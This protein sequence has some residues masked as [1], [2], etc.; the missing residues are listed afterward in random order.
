MASIGENIRSTRRKRG[1]SQEQLADSL[2]VTKATICRYENGA[3]EP[4]YDQLFAIAEALNVTV[5]FL[6]GCEPTVLPP[7]NHRISMVVAVSRCSEAEF[8]KLLN[9]SPE[10]V[11]DLC[12]GSASPSDSTISDICGVFGVDEY[13]L[14]TG[15]G[16]MLD[17]PS[18]ENKIK[19]F[20]KALNGN[21]ELDVPSQ[22]LA[23]LLAGC[24]DNV[25]LEKL[26]DLAKQLCAAFLDHAEKNPE[27]A[28]TVSPDL[29]SMC[30]FYNETSFQI[31]ESIIKKPPQD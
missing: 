24:T 13:W 19:Q 31:F 6:Q 16:K 10:T 23:H 1:L 9:L 30:K 3:R 4:R 8:A 12:S 22:A 5:S 18:R 17:I 11:R 27:W 26:F 7:I 2:G 29:L 15:D 14:R 28:A 21:N 20:L 25:A